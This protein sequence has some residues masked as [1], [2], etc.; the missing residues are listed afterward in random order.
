MKASEL[1]IGNL[2]LDEHTGKECTVDA[3]D[4][5]GVAF[6]EDKTY[7]DFQ[8]TIEPVG[9]PLTQESL[10]TF[11]FEP[12]DVFMSMRLAL[13]QLRSY[14]TRTFIVIA[15]DGDVWIELIDKN[16]HRQYPELQSYAFKCHYVHQLQ[17]LYFALTGEELEIKVPS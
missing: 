7:D 4:L 11:G 17:N 9:I 6:T 12:N 14:G 5:Y 3:I 10:L 2:V 8:R 13:D 1:R 15:H 16:K